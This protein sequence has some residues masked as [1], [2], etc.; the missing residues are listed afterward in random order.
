MR[1]A[2]FLAL[3]ALGTSTA[4]AQTEL[5]FA[6]GVDSTG[7]AQAQSNADGHVLIESLEYP[8]GLWLHLVDE[9]GDALA[10]IRVEYQGRPDSLVV[11]HCVDPAG[12][13]QETLLWTRSDGTPLRLT[14][15]P[16]GTS[17]LSAELASID[18]QISPSA[19]SLLEP[20]EE[21]RLSGWEAMATF[22][23]ER[24]QGQVGRVAVQLDA[25]TLAIELGHPE[26]VKTLVAHLQ[27]AQQPV[28][29]ALGEINPL[30]MQIFAGSLGLLREGVILFNVPLFEDSNLEA[31]MRQAL[32]QVKEVSSMTS[33][34]ASDKNIHSLVGLRHF[35]ALQTL[36]LNDNQIVDITP[37]NQLTNLKTLDLKDNQIADITPLTQMTDL[38]KLHLSGN[39]IAD[40]TPLNQITNLSE[41][42]LSGNQIVDI[43][44]LNQM[45]DLKKLELSGNQIADITPLAALDPNWLDLSFNQ[46]SDVTP[47]SALDLLTLELQGN[48]I[49][50]LIPLTTLKS[51][52]WLNLG[53]NQITDLTPLSV[54]KNLHTLF[55]DRNQL[56][57]LTPLAQ[58]TGLG[59]LYLGHNQIVD[60]T[61][62]ASLTQLTGLLLSDNRIVDLTPL[63][64]LTNLNRLH[65]HNNRIEDLAPLI[66]NPGIDEGVPRWVDTITLQ[67]NPLSDQALNEQIPAL[68]ARGVAVSY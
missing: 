26:A 66:A 19:T 1:A 7:R 60:L 18:W 61:P 45:M 40:I 35:T 5:Y 15:K 6:T 11:I 43:T 46:I 37:L 34:S 63:T 27:Q 3:T 41:L 50:D 24:W 52:Y 17:D 51:L 23:R 59:W 28:D 36:I 9:A 22:L 57:D 21:I 42:H 62:L 53:S 49:A 39:Q 14:L 47:L 65:L 48:Q 54:L 12:G 16:K 64:P 2:I 32:Y 38:L 31:A 55:L 29:A 20:V 10:G 67:G 4:T 25:N 13:V 44:P 68:K 33:L 56:S 58:L 8:R 30:K